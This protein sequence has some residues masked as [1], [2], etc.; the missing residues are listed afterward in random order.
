MGL[1]LVLIAAFLLFVL[2]ATGMTGDP[3]GDCVVDHIVALDARGRID[4][5]TCGGRSLRGA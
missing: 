3:C 4:R 1:S 5:A 2:G